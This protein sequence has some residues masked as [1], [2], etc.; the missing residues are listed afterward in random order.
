MWLEIVIKIE[1]NVSYLNI[2]KHSRFKGNIEC[3]ININSMGVVMSNG[4]YYSRRLFKYFWEPI[5][6]IKTCNWK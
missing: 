3:P 4:C 6:K 1:Y 2:G 5:K